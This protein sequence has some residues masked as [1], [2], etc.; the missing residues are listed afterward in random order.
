MIETTSKDDA[1]IQYKIFN[2]SKYSLSSS[3][4]STAIDADIPEF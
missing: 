3:L 4:F 2:T 1:D